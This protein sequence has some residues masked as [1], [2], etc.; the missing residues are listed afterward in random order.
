MAGV[1]YILDIFRGVDVIS[2]SA[3]TTYE[4]KLILRSIE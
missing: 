1:E 3:V 2:A 4:T